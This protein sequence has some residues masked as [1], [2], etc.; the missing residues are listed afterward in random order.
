MGMDTETTYRDIL[1]N[2]LEERCKA[3]P[4]YSMRAFAR[5][6]NVT[7]DMISRVFNGKKG[8][9]EK[10]AEK[11]AT[12]L[13]FTHDEKDFFTN[14]VIESDARSKEKRNLATA[15]LA[16]YRSQS[17]TMTKTRTMQLDVFSVISDWYH[18]AIME[19]MLLDSFKSSSRWISRKL[20]INEKQT[21]LAIERLIR[22]G[23]VDKD[24]K[25]NLSADDEFIDVLSG[26]PSDAIKNFHKQVMEKN[27]QA[28]YTQTVDEREFSSMILAFDKSN[29]KKA[30]ELIRNFSENF[31]KNLPEPKN[32]NS[33]YNL[34]IQ[35]CRIDNK[36][37]EEL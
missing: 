18:F 8:L 31:E 16:K 30:Q 26:P 25:G 37:S 24:E 33:V 32:K 12:S 34:A 5:D 2:K 20:G 23:L 27:L 21:E 17:T 36:L 19:L 7:P 6:M 10:T 35:F 22:L 28:L 13:G 29:L 4:H 15:K 1:K 14:L 9:S 11:I 3:N